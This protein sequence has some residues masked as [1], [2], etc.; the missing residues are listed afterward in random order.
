MYQFFASPEFR[1]LAAL[2]VLAVASVIITLRAP[3]ESD[4]P[5]QSLYLS[6]LVVS[7]IFG[8]SASPLIAACATGIFSVLA[9]GVAIWRES[10]TL[11]SFSCWAR[12]SLP[13]FAAFLIGVPCGIVVRANDLLSFRTRN[14]PFELTRMGFSDVEIKKIMTELASS[15]KTIPAVIPELDKTH[16]SNL[17]SSAALAAFKKQLEMVKQNAPNDA[18]QQLKLLRAGGGENVKKL[19]ESLDSLLKDDDAKMR[20]LEEINSAQNSGG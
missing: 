5:K 6:G 16:S 20:I 11:D 7:L 19:L 10:T 2:L 3:T 18:E 12:W 4:A 9:A 1:V 15:P 17:I 8:L 14:I 13:F